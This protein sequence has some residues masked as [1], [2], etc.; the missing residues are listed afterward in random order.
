MVTILS[1]GGANTGL[2]RWTGSGRGGAERRIFHMKR[3][4]A[5]ALVALVALGGLW[6]FETQTAD[7]DLTLDLTGDSKVGWHSQEPTLT[8][9][10]EHILGADADNA[11]GNDA[12][13]TIELWAAVKS[14]ENVQF[15]LTVTGEAMSSSTAG[16]DTTIGISAVGEDG[17][18]G[19]SAV[20]W[21]TESPD[22]DSLTMQEG[23]AG[24]QNRVVT[25]KITFSMDGDDYAAAVAAN[26]YS[27]DVTLTVDVVS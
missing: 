7:V 5:I 21:E 13:S 3:T 14:N 19:T 25:G 18:F 23:T 11:F 1:K 26:D 2:P 24:T 27:A 16:V 17:G 8:T 22:V 20:E 15:K 4:I 6:A 10:D 9:W 12:A